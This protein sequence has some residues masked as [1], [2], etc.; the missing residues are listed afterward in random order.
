MSMKRIVVS[1][2][3]VREEIARG[4]VR[5]FV[6][7][8]AVVTALAA[9]LA[10]SRGVTIVCQDAATASTDPRHGPAASTA[11]GMRVAIGSDHGGFALKKAMVEFLLSLGAQP[12]DIGTTSE[13]PCDYPDFAYL[14]ARTVVDG[15]AE[16]GIMID[17]AGIGSCMVVNKV[18]GIRGACCAH[19]FTAR[20]AREH[21]NANILTLGSRVVGLEVAKGIVRT[22]VETMFAG[23]RHEVRVNK[24]MDV[25]RKFFRS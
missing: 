19:E 9:E 11:T 10:A 1:E 15:K 18:P 24:I 6:P 14:V 2:Q 7:N 12:I 13:D 5:M 3:T 4:S 22:F 16:I 25:E 20:N 17:G 21:N 23:G 8:D